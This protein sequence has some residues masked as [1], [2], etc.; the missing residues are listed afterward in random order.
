MGDSRDPKYSRS[1]NEYHDDPNVDSDF[2]AD[3]L[4]SL[5]TGLQQPSIEV[6]PK[7]AIFVLDHQL[8]EFYKVQ[9]KF[10]SEMQALKLSPEVVKVL[11]KREI[12]KFSRFVAAVNKLENPFTAHNPNDAYLL[13]FKQLLKQSRTQEFSN[14]IPIMNNALVDFTSVTDAMDVIKKRD[15]VTLEISMLLTREITDQFSKAFQNLIRWESQLQAMLDTYAKT[16]K[17]SDVKSAVKEYETKPNA[18]EAEQSLFSI[19]HIHSYFKSL[20]NQAN[21]LQRNAENT[22][23]ERN[24]NALIMAVN[25]TLSESPNDPSMAEFRRTIESR[26]TP[27]NK[28]NFI[29]KAYADAYLDG[30]TKTALGHTAK[31]VGLEKLETL[32]MDA[33]DPKF[34][35]TTSEVK[36]DEII[37]IE[38][39]HNDTMRKTIVGHLFNR[40]MVEGIGNNNPQIYVNAVK[41]I[42]RLGEKSLAEWNRLTAEKFGP[43]SLIKIPDMIYSMEGKFIRTTE[44]E[45]AA[46]FS[47]INKNLMLKEK[48]ALLFYPQLIAN[49]LTNVDRKHLT[50]TESYKLDQFI[51]QYTDS[52][53]SDPSL[54]HQKFL[55]KYLDLYITDRRQAGKTPLLETVEKAFLEFHKANKT[56]TSQTKDRDDA[57]I[58]GTV[59]PEE[60][61]SFAEKLIARALDAIANTNQ[62]EFV[63]IIKVVKRMKLAPDWDK[64]VAARPEAANLKLEGNK[65]LGKSL[66]EKYIKKYFETLVSQAETTDK[67]AGFFNR[68]RDVSTSKTPSFFTTPGSSAPATPQT[69][70]SPA[71]SS[72]DNETPPLPPPKPYKR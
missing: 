36:A 39:A 64:L 41:A 6:G 58:M 48:I 50:A 25:D 31:S 19:Y 3:D 40:A 23:L 55:D 12:E 10:F 32:L 2:S 30:R 45:S 28:I 37:L 27:E 51:Q 8:V 22:E 69:T 54:G 65:A 66:D 68:L 5:K 72:S 49:A 56:A 15:S 18:T 46:T 57:L 29:A 60:K 52:A 42:V 21:E 38:I 67:R 17:I 43:D 35:A 70:Q 26:S 24:T 4:R 33:I 20:A 63:N 13:Q 59:R 34:D 1:A 7:V 47:A 53:V 71:S 16:M 44:S 14:A 61:A 9:A 11:N 62:S